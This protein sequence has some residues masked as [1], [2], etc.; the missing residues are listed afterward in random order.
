MSLNA[1]FLGQV[2]EKVSVVLRDLQVKNI[3]L[4]RY[5]SLKLAATL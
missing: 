1:L 2:E 4:M 5:T 3:I